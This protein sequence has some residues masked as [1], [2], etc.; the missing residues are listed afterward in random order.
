MQLENIDIQ[1]QH[2][3]LLNTATE[4][5]ILGDQIHILCVLLR[6]RNYKMKIITF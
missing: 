4:F 1:S 2:M 6:E 3:N 5:C